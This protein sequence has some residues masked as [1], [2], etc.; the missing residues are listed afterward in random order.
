MGDIRGFITSWADLF[1]QITGGFLNKFPGGIF[2][3]KRSGRPKGDFFG[4]PFK[5]FRGD[6]K[7]C[8]WQFSHRGGFFTVWRALAKI[9]AEKNCEFFQKVLEFSLSEGEGGPVFVYYFKGVGKKIYSWYGGNF[10]RDKREGLSRG[11]VADNIRRI[12]AQRRCSVFSR[13]KECVE[14]FPQ[15]GEQRY[16]IV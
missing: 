9:G 12:C 13:P 6:Y 10:N 15:G 2:F 5:R 11:V 7:E 14:I 8:V 1:G 4:G 3:S 16:T